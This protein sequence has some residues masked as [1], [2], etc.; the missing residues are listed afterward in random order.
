[1]SLDHDVDVAVLREELRI[2]LESSLLIA[3]NVR[4]VVVKVNVF[5]VLREQVFVRWRGGWR[6]WRRRLG[7]GNARSS[8]LRSARSFGR[9]VISGGLGRRYLLGPVRLHCTDAVDRNIG[10]VGR[11]PRQRGG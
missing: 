6:R 10:G 11:L 2:R 4:L 8:F 5:H 1:M 7:D 9:Q 3:A